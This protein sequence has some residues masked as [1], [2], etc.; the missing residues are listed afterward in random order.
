VRT[1]VKLRQ[2]MQPSPQQTWTAALADESAF[3]EHYLGTAGGRWPD[4][5][6]RRLDPSLPLDEEQTRWVDIPPG[7]PVDILDVGAGALTFL[8]KV[9]AGRNVRISAV[10]PL[11]AEFDRILAAHNIVPPIRTQACRAEDVLIHFGPNKFDLVFCRNAMDHSADPLAGIRAGLQVA[12][13]GKFLLM[14]HFAQEADHENYTGL[15]QW[16]FDEVDGKFIIYNREHRLDVESLIRD[17]CDQIVCQ[18]PRGR[19]LVTALRRT[20]VPAPCT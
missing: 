12:K 3:W 19:L 5:F 7:N 18:R 8:G 10:D 6:R 1:N 14:H 16:N 4:D 17:L 15:H 9:W 11:A 13:P 2:F 20:A